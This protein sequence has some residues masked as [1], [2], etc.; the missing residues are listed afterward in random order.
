MATID[1]NAQAG[2]DDDAKLTAAVAAASNGDTLSF[3]AKADWTFAGNRTIS[4]ELTLLGDG[5]DVTTLTIKPT[6]SSTLGDRVAWYWNQDNTTFRDMQIKQAANASGHWAVWM[7]Y[8]N[9][10]PN[11]TLFQ[12]VKFHNLPEFD[13][14]EGATPASDGRWNTSYADL[15]TARGMY[16][17]YALYLGSNL[18]TPAT[19]SVE[20]DSCEFH[21][22]HCG[23]YM[24][25]GRGGLHV[26]DCTFTG[27]LGKHNSTFNGLD[28]EAIRCAGHDAII[29]RNVF[30]GN[31][32]ASGELLNRAVNFETRYSY[33][34]IAREN[35]IKSCGTRSAMTFKTVNDATGV[36]TAAAAT[37]NNAG[38]AILIHDKDNE[39]KL[40]N[41]GGVYSPAAGESDSMVL[42]KT[43]DPTAI[44]DGSSRARAGFIT[45][46]IQDDYVTEV[47]A[48]DPIGFWKMDEASG[49][50]LAN[51]A[52]KSGGAA[53]DLTLVPGTGG[54]LN[55]A[56]TT[57]GITY[58]GVDYDYGTGN[59]AHAV[60]SSA[61]LPQ[62][63]P[64]CMECVIKYSD[65]ANLGCL[66]RL[67]INEPGHPYNNGGGDGYRTEL[68]LISSQRI[69]FWN[70]NASS[71]AGSTTFT[72][73]FA[74]GDV[75]HIFVRCHAP[76]LNYI[77]VN[78][79]CR[80][81]AGSYDV[82]GGPY[83]YGV[84]SVGAVYHPSGTWSAI[85]STVGLAAVYDVDVPGVR[86]LAHAAALR[87][88]YDLRLVG[89]STS[90]AAIS[91]HGG[92]AVE[93]D[94][95]AANHAKIGD[96]PDGSS[97]KQSAGSIL[98]DLSRREGVFGVREIDYPSGGTQGLNYT[99]VAAVSRDSYS[100]S[101]V[102]I[103]NNSSGTHADSANEGFMPSPGDLR[104]VDDG[105]RL[106]IQS[107]DTVRFTHCGFTVD[108][109]ATITN[110]DTT[111]IT[112]RWDATA[113]ASYEVMSVFVNG[114]DKQDNTSVYPNTGYNGATSGGVTTLMAS[115]ELDADGF[116]GRVGPIM[117]FGSALSD[118]EILAL[119]NEILTGGAGGGGDPDPLVISVT[120]DET[121]AN[122]TAFSDTGLL[123]VFAQSGNS[124]GE[125]RTVT[126]ASAINSDGTITLDSAFSDL[127][128][129]DKLIIL[130]VPSGITVE[131]NTVVGFLDSET[132][133]AYKTTGVYL[134]RDG[135]D[136]TIRDNYFKRLGQDLLI[137]GNA[138]YFLNNI[139]I[140]GNTSTEG[141]EFTPAGWWTF[142]PGAEAR[143]GMSIL[144]NHNGEAQGGNADAPEPEAVDR[145][146]C[147]NITMVNNITTKPNYICCWRWPD[148]VDGSP[149]GSDFG[150][151]PKYFY[152]L[153]L[154]EAPRARSSRQYRTLR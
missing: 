78:G 56:M 128:V 45:N 113:G 119:S 146:V 122:P 53:D 75:L 54:T 47:M 124:L 12:R 42:A 63:Y 7:M 1:V 121:D 88:H 152:N 60:A 120:D 79:V 70:G 143:M 118:A 80:D 139:L 38:E 125:Y 101:D 20:F 147:A 37:Q 72:G 59:L 33:N 97:D 76:T 145:V 153:Q 19:H 149:A 117:F 46:S 40:L 49:T 141:L 111:V 138:K 82:F 137:S 16:H 109:T 3:T 62:A 112:A 131:R 64:F 71:S 30:Q 84:L 4:K 9:S 74:D 23:I 21:F 144:A 50:T 105:I 52:T 114:A 129:A 18:T 123:K 17:A 68:D 106:E 108:S 92:Y 41:Y 116:D 2:A 8:M 81:L 93:S 73:L 151:A 110:T 96:Q 130:G 90:V 154:S 61:W 34:N 32:P 102:I 58:P 10:N 132:P 136:I 51:S 103:A 13:Y 26:H 107:D 94:G 5:K 100:D 91:N 22:A 98:D 24:P 104:D 133:E 83:G 66:M 43:H 135:H 67:T 126:D 29:E 57:A 48:D 14:T 142:L 77:Y 25:Q 148:R 127:S 27:Y 69:Q 89:S 150:L 36:I 44:I 85:D 115:A 39:A 95:T 87:K 99:I 134:W 86:V 15:P 65:N 35:T 55:T 6:S 31:D 140:E 28:G 11:N